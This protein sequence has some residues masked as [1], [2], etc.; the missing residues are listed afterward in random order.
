MRQQLHG[1][2]K[3][4]HFWTPIKSTETAHRRNHLLRASACMIWCVKPPQ[5]E[6]VAART[7]A[8][9]PGLLPSRGG[10]DRPAGHV[11]ARWRC[12]ARRISDNA[13]RGLDVLALKPAAIEPAK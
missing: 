7:R 3:N 10:C 1:C 2:E 4:R 11:T 9:S 6:Y 5:L 8:P 12:R 13:F